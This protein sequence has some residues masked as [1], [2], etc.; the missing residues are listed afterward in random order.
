MLVFIRRLNLIYFIVALIYILCDTLVYQML[1]FYYIFDC[2]V[3]YTLI[4]T[5]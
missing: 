1:Y 5:F 4:E 2:I 3:L